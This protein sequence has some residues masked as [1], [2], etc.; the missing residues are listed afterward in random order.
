MRIR[1]VPSRSHEH[2]QVALQVAVQR[3]GRDFAPGD[4]LDLVAVALVSPRCHV[5]DF[6]IDVVVEELVDEPDDSGQRLDLLSG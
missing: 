1:S 3:T 6:G 5:G 2:R 4:R